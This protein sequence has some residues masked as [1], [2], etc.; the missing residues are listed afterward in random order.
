MNGIPFSTL[1]RP[2]RKK[3]LFLTPSPHT[4]LPKGLSIERSRENVIWVALNV[5]PTP[6]E[7]CSWQDILD[8]KEDLRSKRWDFRRFLQNLA[9]KAQ[10][11]PE[12]RDE[13]EWLANEYK[14]AM[15]THRIKASQSFIDVFVIS[16][17]DRDS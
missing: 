4:N 9:N 11:G 2:D 10:T 17:L 13:I 1:G 3:R 15:D 16:P 6:D 8:F 14:K 12:I 7:S 5:L